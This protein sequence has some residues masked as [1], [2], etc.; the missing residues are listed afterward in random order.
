MSRSNGRAAIG[1][2]VVALLL[3]AAALWVLF[4]GG[5]AR[6]EP[7]RNGNWQ[8]NLHDAEPDAGLPDTPVNRSE[9]VGNRVERPAGNAPV[10]PA[11]NQPTPTPT[12][13]PDAE[14]DPNTVVGRIVYTDR[15][16]APHPVPMAR[17]VYAGREDR[18]IVTA[19]EDGR[20]SFQDHVYRD[21]EFEVRHDDVVFGRVSRKLRY[22]VPARVDLG[23]CPVQMAAE[24]DLYVLD[25]FGL[26]VDDALVDLGWD[27]PQ[28]EM[29]GPGHYHFR[30]T[31][32]LTVYHSQWQGIEVT[33]PLE[34]PDPVRLVVRLGDAADQRFRVVDGNGTGLPGITAW[35]V[36]EIRLEYNF[37]S[38][39]L[40]PEDERG[41][42]D[43]DG[44]VVIRSAADCVALMFRGPGVSSDV[45]RTSSRESSGMFALLEP[46]E[47]P[48]AR[49]GVAA[50]PD[51]ERVVVVHPTG[52]VVGRV[53]GNLDEISGLVV[54]RADGG[55]RTGG[56][57]SVDGDRFRFDDL[58]PG[59]WVLAGEL[60][61][62]P[63]SSVPGTVT[64]LGE[65]DLSAPSFTLNVR[66]LDHNGIPAE[67]ASVLEGW[68]PEVDLF[69]D[70]PGG[71]TT[72]E[73]GRV[74][75]GFNHPVQRICAVHLASAFGN[76][77]LPPDTVSG[78]SVEIRLTWLAS[79]V[80][81]LLDGNGDPI[82]DQYMR[83]MIDD[84]V[85]G[86]TQ[87]CYGNRTNDAGVIE[88]GNLTPGVPVC[89]MENARTELPPRDDPRWVD[90]P[91]DAEMVRATI[92]LPDWRSSLVSGV[93]LHA[94]GT[95]AAGAH[96]VRSRWEQN[97]ES[98]TTDAAGR[99]TMPYPRSLCP[100]L[101]VMRAPGV[102]VSMFPLRFPLPSDP[103]TPIE[104]RLP[105]VAG[106]LLVRIARDSA[107]AG[108]AGGQLRVE[109]VDAAGQ[110]I[111]RSVAPLRDTVKVDATDAVRFVL[112]EGYWRVRWGRQHNAPL[113]R[114]PPAVVQVEAGRTS[115]VTMR[116]IE[117][118]ATLEVTLVGKVDDL[119]GEIVMAIESADDAL[120]LVWS[121]LLNP[122]RRV[123]LG[124]GE[125]RWRVTFEMNARELTGRVR[126]AAG[127]NQLT[128]PVD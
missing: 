94:D 51:G 65:I 63:F 59:E 101:L 1:V 90:V 41:T 28:P 95:P 15:F 106:E 53:V 98:R 91:A 25:P 89:V 72:D 102:P 84:P 3:L 85:A 23:D 57:M 127:E 52:S 2:A 21:V 99:F 86:P 100:E 67:G 6:P 68:Y 29:V 34:G 79:G 128:I 43:A 37:S 16:G 55:I 14:D 73:H 5:S 112:P 32:R 49:A 103:E 88:I 71:E 119:Q 92:R 97:D 60:N 87:V 11:E 77:M 36:P 107:G 8:A 123:V 80:I 17:L 33:T 108:F 76:I 26:P 75:M 104:I 27:Q 69:A 39:E 111:L 105:A 7:A 20:F 81:T 54:H 61:E 121:S 124:P 122:R 96:L 113:L 31:R 19:D 13:D 42:T 58:T 24:C 115:R 12:D 93:V 125:Y 66:V 109:P 4:G 9:N 46:G 118:P 18:Q 120:D 22:P 126:V 117:A 78:D 10:E 83:C 44:R 74:V 50:S 45:V 30:S 82:V 40:E 48:R 114:F 47:D 62:W 110:P 116:A 35:A 56:T 64:D 38:L 70:P